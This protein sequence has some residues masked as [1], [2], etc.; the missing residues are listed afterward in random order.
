MQIL[1][2]SLSAALHLAYGLLATLRGMPQLYYGDEINLTGG[3]DP[4][5]RKDFPGGF[6]GDEKN[7]FTEAGRNDMEQRMHDWVQALMQLRLHAPA[8]QK[9]PQQTLLAD[10][11]TLAFVR[12]P[13]AAHTCT[14]APKEN[15]YVIVVNND[16]SAQDIS[17]PVGS[18]SVAGCTRY[19]SAFPNQAAATLVA[20]RLQVHLP[21]QEIGI[22]QAQP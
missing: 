20:G 21:A 5:N 13:E 10:K 11:D 4:A 6:P 2:L 17:V 16:L 7:A 15:R 22:F 1:E 3:D 14:I 19:V 18:S 8:L 12:G 9:G